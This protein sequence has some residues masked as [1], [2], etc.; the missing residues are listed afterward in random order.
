MGSFNNGNNSNFNNDHQQ[1]EHCDDPWMNRPAGDS[2]P[3]PPPEGYPGH[4]PRRSMD[5][6]EP[7]GAAKPPGQYQNNPRVYHASVNNNQN[8]HSRSPSPIPSHRKRTP[9]SPHQYRR[10]SVDSHRLTKRVSPAG[11][12]A[13]TRS[14]CSPSPS[15]IKPKL[16]L[17]TRSTICNNNAVIAANYM[18]TSTGG[19]T[20]RN[21]TPPKKGRTYFEDDDRGRNN[22]GGGGLR[23]EGQ[24][25]NINYTVRSGNP[26][27]IS[28]A[29]SRGSPQ[30]SSRSRTGCPTPPPPSFSSTLS[31]S[32]HGRYG[33]DDESGR[34]RSGKLDRQFREP[35]AKQY[36]SRTRQQR[37]EQNSSQSRRDVDGG[38]SHHHEE[39]QQEFSARG[40]THVNLGGYM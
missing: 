19:N 8:Y 34:G 1:D 15:K 40:R 33:T 36:S 5:Y 24:I 22:G 9:A 32:Q 14:K 12:R 21:T 25:G 3:F 10:R 37:D 39:E 30:V 38:R 16:D 27:Q 23:K 17:P 29:V 7:K 4:Q 18:S 26:S 31:N 2:R 28:T 6:D 20:P 13:T 35:E 11:S